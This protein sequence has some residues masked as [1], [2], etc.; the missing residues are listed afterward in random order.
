MPLYLVE[1]RG[2]RSYKTMNF[3]GNCIIDWR[4]H[5]WQNKQPLIKVTLLIF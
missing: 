5:V 2:T 4:D 1:G 3:L